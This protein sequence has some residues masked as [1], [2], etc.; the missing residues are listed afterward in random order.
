MLFYSPFSEHAVGAGLAASARSEAGISQ[1]FTRLAG[2]P[3]WQLLLLE[4][5][6]V[7]QLVPCL[8][9]PDQAVVVQEPLQ[10]QSQLG[11]GAQSS[12]ELEKGAREGSAVAVGGTEGGGT[13]LAWPWQTDR[14]PGRAVI[15]AL[16]AAGEREEER[17]VVP[18]EPPRAAGAGHSCSPGNQD[19]AHRRHGCW[20]V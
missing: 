20:C 4:W 8:S 7:S 17:F 12:R 14:L 10:D 1:R 11:F 6:W 18:G 9:N 5:F 15:A 16:S 2:V 3:C 19:E 13:G